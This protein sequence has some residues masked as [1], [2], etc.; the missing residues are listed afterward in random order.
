M[1]NDP[2]KTEPAAPV[3]DAP[4]QNEEQRIAQQRE[5]ALRDQASRS[6]SDAEAAKARVAVLEGELSKSQA[7]ATALRR[8]NEALR[9]QLAG[10]GAAVNRGGLP[11]LPV[12]LPKNAAQLLESV[13]ILSGPNKARTDAR[14]GDVVFVSESAPAL[15]KLR[16]AIGLVA[17]VHAISEAQAEELVKHGLVRAED[18]DD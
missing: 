10:L 18:L 1:P 12:E 15:D 7:D 6:A 2:K 3:A 13:T 8:E 16:K 9:E 5:G 4:P 14:A 17:N 11:Q